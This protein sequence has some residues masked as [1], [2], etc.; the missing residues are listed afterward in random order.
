MPMMELGILT[1]RYSR[2]TL[3]NQR[4]LHFPS[5]SFIKIE[6]CKNIDVGISIGGV[7]KKIMKG[8]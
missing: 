1:L 3:Q 5:F 7:K 2:M 8:D 4:I 6:P